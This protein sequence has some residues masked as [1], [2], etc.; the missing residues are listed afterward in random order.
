MNV[1]KEKGLSM[2]LK[3]MIFIAL[4]TIN[5]YAQK[6]FS[7]Q[8]LFEKKC[9]MCHNINGPQTYE[10]KKAMVAPPITL[11][12]KSVTIGIDALEE[13]KTKEELRQQTLAFLSDYIMR[14]HQDKA[15]CEETI[16]KRFQTMPSLKGFIKEQELKIV[17]EYVYDNFAPKQH[18]SF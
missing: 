5:L 15:F 6:P 16:F 9:A 1:S 7:A 8:Q 13:P 11:A 17:L 18:E 12:M 3:F 4:F 10:E 2:I 14:P